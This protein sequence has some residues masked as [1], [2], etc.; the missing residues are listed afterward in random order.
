MSTSPS[1]NVFVAAAGNEFMR[2]IA[3]N[4]AEAARQLGRDARVVS[5]RLPEADGS[6]NFVVAPH[7]FFVLSDRPTCSFTVRKARMGSC[8][9]A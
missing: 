2:D 3:G 9:S 5:D 6:V 8:G 1:V 7:E 4:I